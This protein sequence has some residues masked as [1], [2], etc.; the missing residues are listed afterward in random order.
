MQLEDI[1]KYLDICS[2]TDIDLME[3]ECATGIKYVKATKAK[4]NIPK[5]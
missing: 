4:Y 1:P 5:N 2:I 3:E